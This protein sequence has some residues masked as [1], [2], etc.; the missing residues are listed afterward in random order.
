M[1]MDVLLPVC[2]SVQHEQARCLQKLEEASDPPELGLYMA[3][4][5]YV[6]AGN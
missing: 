6:G 5:H 1:G 3:V 4:R 2:M